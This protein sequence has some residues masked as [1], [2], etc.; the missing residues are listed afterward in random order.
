MASEKE[1]RLCS[2]CKHFKN[3][4]CRQASQRSCIDLP[5]YPLKEY[6][7]RIRGEGID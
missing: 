7:S 3:S 6:L 5:C 1:N 2:M 4:H